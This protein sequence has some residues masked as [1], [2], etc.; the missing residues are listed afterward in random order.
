MIAPRIS[1]VT[2][3][4][5]QTSFIEEALQSV[6]DQRYPFLEHIVVD[7]AST[8]RTVSILQEYSQRPGWQH[9]RWVSEPDQ[10]QSDAL[11][12]GFRMA[13]GDII[14]W[15]NSDDRYRR[16]CCETISKAR[17][18]FPEVDILYGDYSYINEEGRCGA[19]DG[20]SSSAALYCV[21]ITCF[22][23]PRPLPFS[24]AA[25][26]TRATG[27]T[28]AIS[29]QWTTNSSSAYLTRAIDFSTYPGSH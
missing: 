22:T 18:K 16:A 11:N 6:K 1:I 14:G 12:K 24:G 4:Y 23:Y 21:T 25:S 28:F 27:S 7:G 3:S 10:G 13:K 29:M 17:A 8:D 20:R 9:L 19:S 26:L 2:P 5:N 15:L